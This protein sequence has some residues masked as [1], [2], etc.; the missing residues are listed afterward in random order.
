MASVVAEEED[1][2]VENN[3]CWALAA[4]ERKDPR[5]TVICRDKTK[6]HCDERVKSISLL[7]VSRWSLLVLS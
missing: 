1:E 4:A 6:K 2:E 5:V 7:A 3:A